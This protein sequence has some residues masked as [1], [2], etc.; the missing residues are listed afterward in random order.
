MPDKP[1]D[2]QAAAHAAAVQTLNDLGILNAGCLSQ[3]ELDALGNLTLN[4]L[5]G[6]AKAQQLLDKGAAPAGGVCG[7]KIF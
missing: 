4:E 6:L 1:V 7:G 3:P 5:R 2:A